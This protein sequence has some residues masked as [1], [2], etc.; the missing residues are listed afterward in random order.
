MAG[1]TEQ[2]KLLIV[3]DDASLRQI[4]AWGFEDLGYAVWTAASCRQA[5]AIARRVA[6]DCALLDF[7][8]PDGTGHALSLE[9]AERLPQARIVLMSGNRS[10]AVADIDEPPAAAAFVDKPV[11]LGRLNRFFDGAAEGAGAA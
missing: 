9:L 5:A 1:A 7:W 3:D 11:Q 4:L 10:A 2:R 8:L 6:F